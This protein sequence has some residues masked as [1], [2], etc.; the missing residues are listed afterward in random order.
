MSLGICSVLIR[1]QGLPRLRNPI[2]C[3]CLLTQVSVILCVM[4]FRGFCDVSVEFSFLIFGSMRFVVSVMRR[5]P[6]LLSLPL[7]C[8]SM[9]LCSFGCFVAYTMSC[10]V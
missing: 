2:R 7:S 4:V 9:F 6:A 8:V 1:Y 3:L 5:F 10:F